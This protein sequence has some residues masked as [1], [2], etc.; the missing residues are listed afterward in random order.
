MSQAFLV[1]GRWTWQSLV[2][3]GGRFFMRL[4]AY[5][6]PAILLSKFLLQ[7]SGGALW[8]P[9]EW[10]NPV[11][12]VGLGIGMAAFNLARLRIKKERAKA[13]ARAEHDELE[14]AQ[15]Q[16]ERRSHRLSIRYYVLSAVALAG[17]SWLRFETVLPFEPSAD[18]VHGQ[19]TDNPEPSLEFHR[20][21]PVRAEQIAPPVYFDTTR[22][23]YRG[24][25]LVPLGFPNTPGGLELVDQ[26]RAQY[27]L[28]T[29]GDLESETLMHAPGDFIDVIRDDESRWL[30][31]TITAFLVCYLAVIYFASRAYGFTFSVIEEVSGFF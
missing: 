8:L 22:P 18:W 3:R 21:Y 17:F 26:V 28:N 10:R 5:G 16:I 14:K 29:E 30:H 1:I 20:R 13:L 15:D 7:F 11:F 2:P 23:P 31:L 24:H 6:V 27:A 19:Y 9:P 4:V 25:I 12:A